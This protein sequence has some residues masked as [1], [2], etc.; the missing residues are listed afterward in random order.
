ML[1][2]IIYGRNDSH[3]YN[4]HKRAAISLNCIAEMLSH[5][6]DEILFVD[7]NTP[8]DLPTFIEAI[9]DTL[10]PKAKRVL[11]VFRVRPELHA[12]IAGRTH[13]VALEPHARNI[14]IRRSNPANRWVLLTNTDMIFI[15]RSGS[16][17]LSTAVEDVADGQY[18]LPRYDLPEPLWESFPRTDPLAVMET[19]RN[20]SRVLHLDEITISHPYMRF[21]APGDFQLVPRQA[22]FEIRGFDERMIHGWHA[23]SNMCKRLNLFYG[24]RTE[25]LAHRLKGYHCDHTRVATGTH[26]QDVKLENDLYEFVY[27][28]KDPI[29]PGQETTWG[30]PDIDVE[31]VDFSRGPQAQFVPA[32]QKVLE[33]P[34]TREYYSDANDVRNYVAYTAEHVLPYVAAN[35]TVYPRDARFVYAGNHL[36]MLRLLSRCVRE[37]GFA[38]ALH[39]VPALLATERPPE[40]SVPLVC[41][42]GI[43]LVDALSEFT[44]VLFD[45]G[46]DA[47]TVNIPDKVLR[48]TDWPRT[49][50]YSIGRVLRLIQRFAEGSE[51]RWLSNKRIAEILVLNGNRHI[52][53]AFIER[54]LMAVCTPY[55]TRV[56]KGRPRVGSETL[57]R[58]AAWKDIEA[59]LRA[60]F[61]LDHDQYSA[62]SVKP[63][64]AIDLTSSG[65]SDAYKDGHWG[66]IDGWGCWTDGP[67]VEIVFPVSPEF[68]EDFLVSLRVS[69]AFIGLNK[70]PI[71][72]STSLDGEPLGSSVLAP[73]WTVV[74]LRYFLSRGLMRDK[75]DCRLRLQIENPQSVQAVVDATGQLQIGE[76]PQELGIR[77]Q[78]ISF[79]SNDIL[80]LPLGTIIDFTENGRGLNHM[81]E[82]WTQPDSLGSWSLGPESSLLFVLEDRPCEGA[83]A[84]L[85]VTDVAVNDAHPRLNVTV[86]ANGEEMA[87]WQLGPQRTPEER[88][89]FLPPN[90]LA[91][92]PLRLSFQIDSPRSPHELGWTQGDFRPLG[93]RLTRFRLDKY[94]IP[95]V[96]L[97]ETIDFTSG[98]KGADLL[99]GEWASP[100]QYGTWTIGAES[101]MQMN[102]DTGTQGPVPA[103]F[104]ISDC[105]VSESAPELSVCVKANGK[106][107]ADWNFGPNRQPHVQGLELPQGVIPPSGQLTL[108]FQVADPRTPLSLGWSADPRPLGIRIARALFGADQLAIPNFNGAAEETGLLSQM[109]RVLTRAAGRF[110]AAAGG[111]A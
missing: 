27:L 68:T 37:M 26:R 33:T 95:R 103:A 75:Q 57:Y 82:Y 60:V 18:I 28:V 63:G 85:T 102:L 32:L 58:S 69:G 45:L 41:P 17:T 40:D 51:V 48:I 50:R 31:Q 53:S 1:S 84:R 12:R 52:F 62:S 2:A 43:E 90:A 66:A 86:L 98:G 22:L 9:Y 25:S 81:T 79:A 39:Y 109:T 13:L 47:S 92:T 105:M 44:L 108:T 49:A 38:E 54:F 7:Y 16:W 29:A 70:E 91:S 15:P 3:G 93:F 100:D 19:C 110:K 5:E 64:F 94:E 46:L 74:T 99:R 20:L 67:W 61:G 21:D 55:T 8:N 78:S 36:G 76:N 42:G 35:L 11:R 6:D 30:A 72:V 89:F 73:G 83:V 4:L 96:K 14:A 97:G 24:N 71:R 34:Q 87:R 107:V 88:S 111:R 65:H 104:V 80:K 56:R 106:P 10:T 23:D 101:R 77:V 59:Q